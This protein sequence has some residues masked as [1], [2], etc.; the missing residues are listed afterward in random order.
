[1]TKRPDKRFLTPAYIL[2][3]LVFSPDFWRIVA[4]FLLAVFLTPSFAPPDLSPAGRAVLYVMVAAIGWAVTAKPGKWIA[5]K[6]K[7]LAL[8]NSRPD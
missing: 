1:M 7:E 8:G 4:G 5:G 3:Y 6:V 2:F